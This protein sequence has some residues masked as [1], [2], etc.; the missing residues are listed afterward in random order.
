MTLGVDNMLLHN[1]DY[2][3]SDFEIDVNGD[4][5]LQYNFYRDAFINL[6]RFYLDLPQDCGVKVDIGVSREWRENYLS[7]ENTMRTKL[8]H[9]LTYQKELI[10]KGYA[11][12][13]EIDKY[14]AYLNQKGVEKITFVEFERL[15][16]LTV[17]CLTM[18]AFNWLTPYKDYKEY[19]Y[20]LF[21]EEKGNMIYLNL[22][23]TD[24]FPHFKLFALEL[25]QLA[26]KKI[27]HEQLDLEKFKD[28]F[29]CLQTFGFFDADLEIDQNIFAKLD[30]III[31]NKHSADA[32][33]AY[34]NNILATRTKALERKMWSYHQIYAKCKA[35]D[36]DQQLI[37]KI[38]SISRI[39]GFINDE[40]ELRHM[41]QMRAQ[42]IIKKVLLHYDLP[43][44]TITLEELLPI[45]R[46]RMA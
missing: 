46:E 18:M 26:L 17:E 24:V 33:Q 4:C 13:N 36:C 37:Q 22:N 6:Y 23:I 25:Y 35:D 7:F 27:R 40:E 45:L 11:K 5:N 14:I 28:N 32:I 19:F 41:F 16:A 9:D 12:L 29:G 8:V 15:I 2:V 21:D 34:I 30:E 31:D 39:I 1:S 38:L 43:L 10:K 20:Q 42:R 3:T 44:L